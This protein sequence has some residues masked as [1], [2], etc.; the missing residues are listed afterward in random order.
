MDR[1]QVAERTLFL[2][3]NEHLVSKGCFSRGYTHAILPV[4]YGE[5]LARG[6]LIAQLLQENTGVPV[7]L[8]Q[9]GF[10]S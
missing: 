6:R 9:V 3:N 2:W 10:A 5:C 1:L 4:I 7:R 8:P